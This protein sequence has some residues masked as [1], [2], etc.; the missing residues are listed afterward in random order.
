MTNTEISERLFLSPATVKSHINKV[1]NKLELR[2]RV[3]A[4]IL[5]H[6]LN[7]IEPR[8]EK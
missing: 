8:P 7:L 1:F 6:R 4:V 5:A 3:Q 2:D